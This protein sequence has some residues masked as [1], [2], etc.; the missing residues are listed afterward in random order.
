MS[1]KAII[2]FLASSF[3]LFSQEINDTAIVIRDSLIISDTLTVNDSL[4]IKDYVEVYDTA[5]IYPKHLYQNSFKVERDVFLRNDYR[6]TGNLIEPFQ[7]NFI[8]DLGLPGQSNETF[9]YG[10]GFDG[11]SYLMD[12]MLINDRNF[13]R[14]DLNL[15]QSEDI[16]TIEILPS[17]RGFL[18]SPFNNPVTVN[19]ITR[20]FIPPQPYSR[21]KYY[22]G[23]Y[24]EA[25]V[26]GSFN[27]LFSKNFQFSFDV[28]NRKYDSSYANTAFSTWQAKAKAKYFFNNNFY[29]TAS[30]NYVTRTT[31]LWEGVNRD[32]IVSLGSSLEELL[33]EPDFAPVNSPFKKQDDLVHFSTL[34]L[35]SVQSENSRTELTLFQSFKEMKIENNTY[36]EYDNSTIGVNLGQQ[37]TFSPISIYLKGD[38]E[39]NVLENWMRL[40]SDS[41][42][43]QSYT[44]NFLSFY[45]FSGSASLNVIDNFVPSVFYKSSSS[46]FKSVELNNDFL[47]S[48]FGA[49]V[50]YKPINSLSLYIGYSLF[51]K[52]Y[53][54]DDKTNSFETGITYKTEN[55]FS[56]LKYFKRDNSNFYVQ[57]K[58]E[59][60]GR[61]A[62]FDFNGI[63]LSANLIYWY[64]QFE[65]SSSAYFANSGELNSVPDYRFTGGLYFRGNLFEDNL[66]LKSGLKFTYTG[67]INLITEQYGLLVVDP[68]YKLDFILS[69]EIRK[70]AIVYFTVENILDRKYFITPYYPMPGISL[71]FGLAWEFLN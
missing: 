47:S 64:L 7:F 31:G 34:R 42:F 8:K 22:Q 26:D 21:I 12:G 68:S 29:L 43:I 27:A 5:I 16:E 10:V 3:L 1:S 61:F 71:R 56:D 37:I 59:F 4:F 54:E 30:Y 63:A 62:N 13:N 36:A 40:R 15:V 52:T 46:N 55:I 48:G 57:N 49:D 39:R 18:Y 33:Y 58:S 2:I 9:I 60:N 65:T 25:M 66:N 23:P 38:Y 19:F 51:D 50:I 41:Y 28:T 6:Y 69:G 44:K 53:L 24:G 32:S 67:E 35:T 70:A 14:L 45:S 17:P 20:D 11:I